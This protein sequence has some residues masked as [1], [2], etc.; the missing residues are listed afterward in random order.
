MDKF[1][2]QDPLKLSFP[3]LHQ[4]VLGLENFGDS[5]EGSNEAILEATSRFSTAGA[6]ARRAAR[7][8]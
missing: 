5:P 1:P 6:N 2:D 8:P 7:K 4:L 3:K